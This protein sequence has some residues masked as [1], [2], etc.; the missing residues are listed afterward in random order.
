[1][2]RL[3]SEKV[4]D[5]EVP[6]VRDVFIYIYKLPPKLTSANRFVNVSLK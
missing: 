6:T 2:R 5:K 4:I 3:W 1:M